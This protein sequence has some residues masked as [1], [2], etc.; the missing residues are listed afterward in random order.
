MQPRIF[1]ILE[2]KAHGS[3]SLGHPA[4][5]A[6]SLIER[7]AEPPKIQATRAMRHVS[8]IFEQANEVRLNVLLCMG[9]YSKVRTLDPACRY[10]GVQGPCIGRNFPLSTKVGSKRS[11]SG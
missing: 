3:N 10:Y 11:S 6:A 2:G 4:R 5:L 1:F 7:A 9:H 8:L